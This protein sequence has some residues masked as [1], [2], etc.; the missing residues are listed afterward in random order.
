MNTI[1]LALIDLY[2]I[3]G[4]I[5]L[6]KIPFWYWTYPARVL[7]FIFLWPFWLV[8]IHKER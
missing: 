1:I 8:V 2:L 7:F 5:V 6:P 4:L 3:I